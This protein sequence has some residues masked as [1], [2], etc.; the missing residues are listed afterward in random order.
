MLNTTAMFIKKDGKL[1]PA[2]DQDA[3]KLNLFIKSLPEGEKVEMYLSQATKSDKTI[4]QL[5]KVHA[6]IR[7]L[8]QFTG[9]EF[10][11]MKDLVKQKAG[12]YYVDDPGKK[13]VKLKSFSDCSKDELASAIETCISIGHTIGYY[14]D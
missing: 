9:H 10:E 14:V 2:S 13:T 6:T 7:E 12:L 8:A 5:A 11:E 4:G 3:G 1:I